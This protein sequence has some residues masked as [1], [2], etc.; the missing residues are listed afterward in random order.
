MYL[1]GVRTYDPRKSSLTC[2]LPSFAP[3]MI[4]LV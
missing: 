2:V 1:D 4:Y 3:Y